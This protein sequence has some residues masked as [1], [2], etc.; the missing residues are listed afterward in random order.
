MRNINTFL[1]EWDF[2]N[3]WGI[4]QFKNDGYPFLQV[5]PFYIWRWTDIERAAIQGQ[6]LF[7]TITWQRWNELLETTDMLA[8]ATGFP[9]LSAGLY[10]TEEDKTL[11]ADHFRELSNRLHD[12]TYGSVASALRNAQTDD[13]VLGWYFIHLETVLNLFE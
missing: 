2:E 8:A 11:K 12:M 1:P 5:M 10:R 7:R 9:A 6:G 4:H 3:I 13:K